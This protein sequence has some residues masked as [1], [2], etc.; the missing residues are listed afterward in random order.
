MVGNSV[1]N[2]LRALMAIAPLICTGVAFAEDA[3][4]RAN[5]T[6]DVVAAE[7]PLN[8]NWSG[9]YMG[10]S[11]GSRWAEMGSNLARLDNTSSERF[12]FAGR[13]VIGGTH[14][15]YLEQFGHLVAGVELSIA[16]GTVEESTLSV[17]VA[18]RSRAMTLSSM[19]QAVGR[20][21]YAQDH[22]LFY[23]KGG[24]AIADVLVSTAIASTGQQTTSSHGFAPGWTAGA[25]CKAR[26]ARGRR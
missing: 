13:G 17:V 12:A 6:A 25:T 4:G 16:T 26:L 9:A 11:I 15:G 8:F 24:F 5:D 14:V 23:A 7:A 20:L 3:G 10:V 21:G 18:D 22:W 19:Y 1:L 2:G